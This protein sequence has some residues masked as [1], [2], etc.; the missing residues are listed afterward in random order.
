MENNLKSPAGTAGTSKL[1]FLTRLVVAVARLHERL[2]GT[3]V[4]SAI[5]TPLEPSL[6]RGAAD[7]RTDGTLG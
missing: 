1:P 3:V 2:H 5:R 7:S 6:L 4:T